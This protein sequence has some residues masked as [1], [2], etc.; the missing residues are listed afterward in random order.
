VFPASD[1]SGDSLPFIARRVANYSLYLQ[2]DSG[3]QSHLWVKILV[4]ET[5][6]IPACAKSVQTQSH[7]EICAKVVQ[8]L[9]AESAPGG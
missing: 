7:P 3:N 4:Q 2:V 9:A 1:V 6:K 5:C 8:T